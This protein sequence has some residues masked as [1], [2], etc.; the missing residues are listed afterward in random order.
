MKYEYIIYTTKRASY[1]TETENAKLPKTY[2]GSWAIE[3][4]VKLIDKKTRLGRLVLSGDQ[5]S[6]MLKELFENV[7]KQ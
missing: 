7:C 6:E 3:S 4:P 5:V 1:I 2:T